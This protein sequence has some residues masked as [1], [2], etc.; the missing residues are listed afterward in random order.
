MFPA[1]TNAGGQCFAFPDACNTPAPPAPPVPVPYP[2]IAMPTDAKGATCSKKVKIENMAVCTLTTQIGRSSGDEAGTA[3]GVVSGKNMGEMSYMMGS[4]KVL[5]EGNPIV[6]QLS[7]TAHNG[8][9]ANM[10]MGTQ[11][12]PSQVKV[13]CAP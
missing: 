9:S 3:G 7:M 8:T 4:M 11:V 6:M 13:L 10:P 1:T 12:A 5:V 2:N